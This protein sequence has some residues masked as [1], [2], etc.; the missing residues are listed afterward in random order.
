M[1]KLLSAFY[2]LRAWEI[3]THFCVATTVIIL[4]AK[5][6]IFFS[7][8]CLLILLF[9]KKCK[10]RQRLRTQNLGNLKNI[11]NFMYQ[12]LIFYSNLLNHWVSIYR[13]MK[14][15]FAESL[16]FNLPSHYVSDLSSFNLPNHEVSIYR[17]P[18]FQFTDL[19]GFFSE[20]WSFNIY[21]LTE[22]QFTDSW[23]VNWN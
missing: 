1:L 19:L 6:S 20:S 17:I 12:F 23:L 8:I 16:S 18:M 11:Q 14:F 4:A 7:I 10:K 9:E 22:F 13:I 15:Q 21:R 5:R 2:A 3:E